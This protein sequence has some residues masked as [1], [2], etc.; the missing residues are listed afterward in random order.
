MMVY[1]MCSMHRNRL[2]YGFGV[3]IVDMILVNIA[4]WS[5]FALSIEVQV[6]T[7]FI[8]PSLITSC[9]ELSPAPPCLETPSP[10]SY[11]R[12]GTSVDPVVP[13]PLPPFRIIS[14]GVR[15][16]RQGAL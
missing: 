11:C 3:C 7:S 1:F 12:L 9:S 2:H 6:H 4:A 15:H 16:V 8:K 10:S 14:T 13:L 5:I